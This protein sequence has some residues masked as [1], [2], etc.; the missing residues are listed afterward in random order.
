M[1]NLLIID[2][3]PTTCTPLVRLLNDAGHTATCASGPVQAMKYLRAGDLDLVLLDLSMPGLDGFDLLQALA[4]EPR[5]AKVPVAVYSGQDDPAIV[6]QA[7]HLGARD[8]LTKG[9]TWDQLSQRIDALLRDQ[10]DPPADQEQQPQPW[11]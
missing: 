9:M 11:A 5:Y 8:F 10:P 1:S 6:A 4:E 3:D 7:M 2:D